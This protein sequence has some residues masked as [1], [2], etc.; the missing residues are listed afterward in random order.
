[1]NVSINVSAQRYIKR[2]IRS[3]E[4]S[5]ASDVVNGLLELVQRE[6][7]ARVA[8]DNYLRSAA[9][10]GIEDFKRGDFAVW[11]VDEIKSAGRTLLS[12]SRRKAAGSPKPG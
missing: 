2:K 6:E 5:N 1:M 10:A 11:D 3:G 12:S 7:R 4:F 8:Y 9:R